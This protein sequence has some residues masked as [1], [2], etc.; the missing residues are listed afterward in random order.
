MRRIMHTLKAGLVL[1]ALSLPTQAADFGAVVDDLLRSNQQEQ[2]VDQQRFDSLMGDHQQLQAE[3]AQMKAQLETLEQQRVELETAFDENEQAL[4][5]GTRLLEQANENLGPIKS[6]LLEQVGQTQTLLGSSIQAWPEEQAQLSQWQ[7]AEAMP[8]RAQLSRY[9][10]LLLQSIVASGQVEQSSQ[11]VVQADGSMQEQSVWRIGEFGWLDAQGNY[12]LSDGP[13]RL[14]PAQP[15]PRIARANLDYLEGQ[16]EQ[17]FLDPTR[18]AA[19]DMLARSPSLTERLQQAGG[20]GLVI[21]ALL[22]LGFLIALIRLVVLLK[23]RAELKS[24]TGIQAE[25]DQVAEQYQSM[26]LESLQLKL[27]EQA[28]RYQPKLE[29]GLPMLKLL[30]AIS[31]MLGLLGTVSGMIQTFQAITLT[32]SNDPALLAGGISMALMTTVLGL[33]AAIPL[34]LIHNGLQGMSQGITNQ[35]ELAIAS[36]LTPRLERQADA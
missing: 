21:G 14:A 7:D 19:L 16:G 17:I 6:S 4:V 18:G 15:D 33:V 8:S 20:V 34:L 28:L 1:V 5:E 26:D 12:L 36:R 31:P 2:S 29:R 11:P 32:G 9:W 23:A 22:V 10:Q 35:L 25:L 3:L 27:E 30:A 13:L 24:D